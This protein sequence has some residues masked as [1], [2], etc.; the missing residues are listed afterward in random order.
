MPAPPPVPAPESAGALPGILLG[1]GLEA[2]PGLPEG[3][4]S[5]RVDFQQ[6][7]RDALACAA[8]EGWPE[9][10]L[11][12]ADFQDWPLGERAVVE[13]LHAWARRGRRL[14]LLACRYDDVLR[15]H[16]RFVQWRG[17]WDHLLSCRASRSADPLELPSLLWSPGWALHRLD[18]ERCTGV[19]TT[20]PQQRVALREQLREWLVNKSTPGFPASTLG[21]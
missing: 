18:R 1:A 7:V 6:L 8:R 19:A 17:T 5:G 16:A 21:L 20:Q 10:I 14:S 3:R 15:R 9:L 2:A 4:F 13:S 12:D 11:S